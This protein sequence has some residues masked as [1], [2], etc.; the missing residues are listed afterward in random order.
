MFESISDMERKSQLI[1]E[2]RVTFL[3]SDFI[4]EILDLLIDFQKLNNLSFNKERLFD[5]MKE[6]SRLNPKII[7]D[8]KRV[9]Q[10]NSSTK[11]TRLI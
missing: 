8:I 11:H 3:Q 2:K 1:G 5:T 7:D 4:N 6:I 10:R 9:Y